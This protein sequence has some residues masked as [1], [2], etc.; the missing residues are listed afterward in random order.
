MVDVVFFTDLGWLPV[1]FFLQTN[2]STMSNCHTQRRTK[3]SVKDRPAHPTAWLGQN[4]HCL[5]NPGSKP[6]L[7]WVKHPR[8]RWDQ[9]PVFPNLWENALIPRGQAAGDDGISEAGPW[10]GGVCLR[11]SGCF[12]SFFQLFS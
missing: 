1:P 12:F 10:D 8:F 4:C 9:P 7:L 3:V 11:M 2:M 5:K 6:G